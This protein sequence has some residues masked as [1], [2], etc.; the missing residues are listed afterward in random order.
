MLLGPPATLQA[1]IF[2]YRP[3]CP[4]LSLSKVTTATRDMASVGGEKEWER[5]GP[6]VYILAL[7]VALPLP[8]AVS[9]AWT[10]PS[11]ARRAPATPT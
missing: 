6:I 7:L 3:H 2:Q 8:V 10:S 1:T 11:C 4:R 9:I 5:E